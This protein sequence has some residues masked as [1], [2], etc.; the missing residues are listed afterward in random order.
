MRPH[1]FYQCVES[2]NEYPPLGRF[3]VRDMR[4][5]VAVGVI[6]SV[7]KTEK[8]GA[9]K[10]TKVRFSSSPSTL[11]HVSP[12]LTKILGC[13]EGRKEIDGFLRG[14]IEMSLWWIVVF[15]RWRIMVQPSAISLLSCHRSTCVPALHQAML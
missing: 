8:G 12:L 6:K 5:T 1:F 10:V 7:A 3:A 11:P 2:Y 13:S 15:L 9:G 14:K 4:Q